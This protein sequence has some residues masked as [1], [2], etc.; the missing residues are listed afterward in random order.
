MEEKEGKQEIICSKETKFHQKRLCSQKKLH[1]K[2]F[3]LPFTAN[4]QKF[5]FTMHGFAQKVCRTR[6]FV[7]LKIGVDAPGVLAAIRP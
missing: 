4:M 5:Q 3:Q 1:K 2:P 7:G 6:F